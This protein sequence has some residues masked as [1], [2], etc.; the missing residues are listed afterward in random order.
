MS[1]AT[2]QAWRD[3]PGVQYNF[4]TD[5]AR[6]RAAFAGLVDV[7][8]EIWAA[9][10][11]GEPIPNELRANAYGMIDHAHQTAREVVSRLYTA[12]SIDALHAGHRLE[13][14]LRYVHAMSVNWERF[15]Q[16]HFDGARVLFGLEPL[17]PLF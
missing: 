13:Q 12:G 1:V 7:A 17:S 4:A 10:G 5:R 11:S 2:G 15:R 14:S 6:L 16:L 9:A 8:E 3:W